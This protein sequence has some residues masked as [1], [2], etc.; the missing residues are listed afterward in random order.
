MTRPEFLGCFDAALTRPVDFARGGAAL[1]RARLFLFG[2]V[3]RRRVAVAGGSSGGCSVAVEDA[4][5]VA[6]SV[7][8]C[9]NASSL[10]SCMVSIRS[11]GL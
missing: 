3:L 2:V 7:G 8:G 5:V 4:A 6:P 10:G 9:P 1:R 11:A